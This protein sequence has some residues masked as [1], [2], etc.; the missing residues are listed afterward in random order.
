MSNINDILKRYKEDEALRRS[1]MSVFARVR[2]DAIDLFERV[3]DKIEVSYYNMVRGVKNIIAY[4]PIIYKDR[5][6]DWTYLTELMIFK[7][8]RMKRFHDKDAHYVGT[9]KNVK[10]LK[11]MIATLDRITNKDYS[12]EDYD[13]LIATFGE[14]KVFDSDDRSMD[15]VK[16]AI[17]SRE[18]YMEQ[19]DMELFV[20][21]FTKYL[22]SLWD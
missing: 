6:Y 12:S 8:E 10:R 7:M 22:K 2:E 18:R 13:K 20:R 5:E 15:K 14:D 19:Q 1:K 16:A 9:E 11:V 4:A 21:Y 3:R 17:Y